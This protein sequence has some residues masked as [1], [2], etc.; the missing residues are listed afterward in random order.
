MFNDARVDIAG[1]PDLLWRKDLPRAK[2]PGRMNP[3]WIRT[4][5]I[6]DIGRLRDYFAALSQQSRHN[7]FMGTV[8]N[9]AKI[10]SDCLADS[11][12]AD[13]FTLVAEWLGEGHD[14]IIGEASYAYDHDK[15]CG[16]FAI[17]VADRW[18]RQGLGSALLCALQFRA[19]SLGHIELFGE[20]LKS[21]LQMKSLAR[22][23]GFAFGHSLDWR[24]VRLDKTLAGPIVPPWPGSTV[25]VGPEPGA[26][27]QDPLLATP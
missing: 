23:A 21:N 14:A 16:E 5:E 9:F 27:S 3:I 2:V 12:K 6:G 8:G 22:K 4:A 19:V 13:R 10:A 25:R 1:P 17:S 26:R 24:A 15:R 7:R 20:T 11:S 18:Q